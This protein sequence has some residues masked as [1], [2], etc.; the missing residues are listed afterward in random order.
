M[1]GRAADIVHLVFSKAFDSIS[2]LILPG[3]LAA[4]SLD[5]C[6]FHWIKNW[7]GGQAQRVVELR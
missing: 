4:H 1:R 3:K 7:L 6:T 5:K 2:H